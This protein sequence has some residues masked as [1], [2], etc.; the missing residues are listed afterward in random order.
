MYYVCIE[1]LNTLIMRTFVERGRTFAWGVFAAILAVGSGF[2]VSCSDVDPDEE[3]NVFEPIELSSRTKSFVTEG[4][5]FAIQL[6]QEV[7]RQEGKS[8]MVSPLS[9]NL[10]LG[11]LLESAPQCED[12]DKVMDM[13]GYP[14][15]SR[16]EIREF[17]DLMMER[18][19]QMDKKTTVSL[20]NLAVTD[21]DKGKIN[22]DFAQSARTYYHA[23]TESMSF[24][25]PGKV[26]ERVN[27]WA[28]ERT[29]KMIREVVRESD[30]KD[31]TF[32]LANALYFKGKWMGPFEKG[33]TG[34]EM[35]HS[36]SGVDVKVKMMKKSDKIDYGENKT[37]QAVNLPYGNGAFSMQVYLPKAGIDVEG[38]LYSPENITSLPFSLHEVDLWL[39]RF[40][41]E[42]KVD[43][44]DILESMSGGAI[45]RCPYYVLDV[46]SA[47]SA[48]FQVA[49]IKVDEEGTEAAAV[50]VVGGKLTAAPSGEKAVFHADRP[51]VFTITETSTQAVLFA[52]VY[53]GE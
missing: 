52:G 53:R 39:P 45:L 29:E 13:L 9:L 31:W 44:K 17:A 2:V 43:L 10:A 47:L 3:D 23:L 18:L 1:P 27:D 8:F 48:A 32:L 24:S 49:S 12:A 19:P 34:D 38:L 26:A 46:P 42:K 28:Y 7:E 41:I 15:G 35:F 5:R 16:E 36:G 30:V 25:N 4:N 22:P 33:K 40:S 20:A 51:F 21:S 50:T 6:L 11:M 14:E 37:C